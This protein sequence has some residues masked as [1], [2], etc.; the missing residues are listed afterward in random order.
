M[1]GDQGGAC[2]A[3]RSA[4]TAARSDA[5]REAVRRYEQAVECQ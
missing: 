2:S 3:I 5:Q 4:R 1:A